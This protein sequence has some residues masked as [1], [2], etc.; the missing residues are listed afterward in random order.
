MKVREVREKKNIGLN[1]LARETEINAT[2]LSQLERGKK[3]NPS[4]EIMQ[5]ISDAL[6]VPIPQLFFE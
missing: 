2:Y 1:E 4:R 5:K 6:G 3:V